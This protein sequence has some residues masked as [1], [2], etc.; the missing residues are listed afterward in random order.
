[1][2]DDDHPLKLA[3]EKAR[4]LLS[5]TIYERLLTVDELSKQKALALNVTFILQ[6]MANISL[7]TA[8]DEAAVKWQAV[9]TASYEAAEALNAS[10][11]PKLAVAKLMLSV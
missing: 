7:Q 4:Q 8:S 10:A 9:L 5:Q 1:L 2:S 6:Q 3:T 11:Q